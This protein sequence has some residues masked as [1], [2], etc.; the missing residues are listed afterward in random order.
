MQVTQGKVC[1]NTSSSP[2]ASGLMYHWCQHWPFELRVQFTN[3]QHYP[4]WNEAGKTGLGAFWRVCASKT[5]VRNWN[6]IWAGLKTVKDQNKSY[7]LCCWS[8]HGGGTEMVKAP[9]AGR[10][11]K[12]KPRPLSHK[13]I[14]LHRQVGNTTP[15][16]QMKV[17]GSWSACWKQW[18]KQRAGHKS[19]V[20]DLLMQ[21]PL[22][23]RQRRLRTLL[24]LTAFLHSITENWC[25]C[26]PRKK[27]TK[28]RAHVL[29]M[30]PQQ[31]HAYSDQTSQLW[32][33]RAAPNSPMKDFSQGGNPL[34]ERYLF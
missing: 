32:H 16:V 9:F 5:A 13:V 33:L 26:F 12:A 4:R 21:S 3:T 22:S 8:S 27:Q 29:K 30:Y 18:D 7:K 23:W 19:G 2:T 20:N 17:V 34:P 11:K 14:V 10:G 25:C 1:P 15:Q 31:A 24:L 6:M 28:I